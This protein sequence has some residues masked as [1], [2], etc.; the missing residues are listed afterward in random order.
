MFELI[1]ERV[2]G[3]E[4]GVRDEQ[5]SSGSVR[6]WFRLNCRIKP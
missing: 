6:L 4:I 5:D 3:S 2:E 1:R